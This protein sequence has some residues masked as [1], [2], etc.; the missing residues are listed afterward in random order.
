MTS[1]LRSTMLSVWSVLTAMGALLLVPLKVPAQSITQILVR[2]TDKQADTSIVVTNGCTLF[3]SQL[4]VHWTQDFILSK[5]N[6]IFFSTDGGD[7]IEYE[8][9]PYCPI[10]HNTPLNLAAGKHTVSI[11]IGSQAAQVITFTLVPSPAV[12]GSNL[13]GV[14]DPA[15]DPIGHTQ[16]A[17]TA[18]RDHLQ[19]VRLWT[20]GAFNVPFPANYWSVPL[21]WHAAGVKVVAVLNF[22]NSVPRC[23]AP[24]DAD[25]ILKLS[26]IPPPAQSGVWA[27]C[28]G[29]ETDTAAYYTGTTAQLAHLINLAAPILHANGYYVIAPSQLNSLTQLQQLNALGALAGVDAIDRHFYSNSAAGCLAQVDPAAAYAVSIKKDLVCTEGGVRGGDAPTLAAQVKILFGTTG[30]QSRSGTFL[31]FPMYLMASDTLD[32]AAPLTASYARNEPF[33]TAIDNALAN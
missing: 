16:L 22:Q 24:S 9:T 21:H 4:P 19:V 33:A 6:K 20:E 2:D 14:S 15:G 31:H 30:L 11:T 18:T 13:A 28:I 26:S 3:L 27:F 25:W 32:T 12:I 17:A 8:A 7:P 10:G 5:T 23:S 1:I 29:N